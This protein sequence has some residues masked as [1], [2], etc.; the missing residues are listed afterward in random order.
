MTARKLL[1][2][3]GCFK[4]KVAI[5]CAK[6]CMCSKVMPL[7]FFLLLNLEGDRRRSR[8]HNSISQIDV[9]CIT[10]D[11]HL[12][13]PGAKS[14]D[15]IH[16]VASAPNVGTAVKVEPP[17]SPVKTTASTTPSS[18]TE[19]ELDEKTKSRLARKYVADIC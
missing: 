14:R 19:S 15:G 2:P 1:T 18:S 5:K 11:S 3:Y 17:A 6:F 13:P 8:R 16:K 9:S 12:V 4:F 10:K 7:T